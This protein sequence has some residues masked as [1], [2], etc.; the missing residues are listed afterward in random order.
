MSRLSGFGLAAAA[1]VVALI[2][3]TA[4]FAAP[5]PPGAAPIDPAMRTRRHEGRARR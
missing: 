2:T 5:P 4:S 1:L 3:A